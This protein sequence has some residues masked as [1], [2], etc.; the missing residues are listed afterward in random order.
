MDAHTMETFMTRGAAVALLALGFSAPL[1]AQAAGGTIRVRPEPRDSAEVRAVLM[2]RA[3]LDSIMTMM[4]Q[5][6][7][8]PH[9]TPEWN[10]MSA[11][12]DSLAPT[13]P[14][15]VMIRSNGMAMPAFPKGW[16]GL[17]LQE[18]SAK[19]IGPEGYF[20]KYFD[21]PIIISVDPESPAKRAGIVPGDVLMAY[22]GVDLKSRPFNLTQIFI[23]E[24]KLSVGI[25][26]DGEAKEYTLTVA[27]MPKMILDGRLDVSR[28]GTSEIRVERLNPGDP[29]GDNMVYRVPGARGSGGTGATAGAVG[30]ML[31]PGRTFFFSTNGAFG[32][33]LYN[34]GP[35]LAK[36][37]KVET[38]VLVNDITDETP[39]SR[40][41]LQPGDV[42]VSVAGQ[43][44]ASVR[45]LQ[46]AVAKRSAVE[47][48]VVL[49][50][51]RDNHPQKVTVSW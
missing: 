46:E 47:R 48:S 19:D 15:R 18:V 33:I 1:G 7:T 38:G 30:G 12:I 39:A 45:A 50:V 49:D 23:P 43:P 11:K 32:A 16:I 20:V 13:M 29:P 6:Y 14:G 4:R 36:K 9:G 22:D 37:L 34:I 24:K 10:A 27:P 51:M 28:T 3:R 35:G 42:I 17:S 2:S 40:S 26:H 25:R 31:I 41:G 8:L 44:V 21:Y 5:L